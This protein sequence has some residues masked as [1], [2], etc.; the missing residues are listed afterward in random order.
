MNLRQP[1][2]APAQRFAL[3]VYKLNRLDGGSHHNSR[4]V[5]A[6]ETGKRFKRVTR[7]EAFGY[8]DSVVRT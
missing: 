5:A 6:I 1:S 3:A 4:V 7:E 8:I 2:L